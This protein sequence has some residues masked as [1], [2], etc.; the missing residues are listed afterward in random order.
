MCLY[1]RWWEQPDLDIIGIRAGR[2]AAEGGGG[3]RTGGGGRGLVGS[4]RITG[5][6]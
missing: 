3:G 6:A 5:K 1:R 2:E 4:G